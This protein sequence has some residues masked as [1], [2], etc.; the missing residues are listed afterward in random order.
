LKVDS[1][2]LNRAFNPRCVAVVGD[3]KQNDFEW[4]RGQLEFTGKLYSVQVNPDTIA[5]IE[6]L[7]VKN[8]TSLLDI[9]EPVDLAIVAVSRNIAPKVL[10]DC[11]TKD[12][13]AAHF[14]TAGF[15]ETGTEEGR[16]LERQLIERVEDTN[17]HLI[18]PNCMGIFN[19]KL[20]IRQTSDQYTGVSGPVGF[21]AQSGAIAA[22]FSLEAHLQ[23]LDINK[24]VSSGNGI[25]LDA[26]DFLEY[27]GGDPE[28]K[29]IG[30]Y[31]EGVKN[32]RKFFEVLRRVAKLKPVVIWKGGRSEDG[33]RAIASHTGALAMSRTVWDTMVKQCGAVA[34]TGT[35]SLIDTLKALIYLPPVQSD[36]VAVAG[37]SGG[38]SVAITDALAD[39]GFRVPPLTQESYDELATFFNVV[40][41]SYRNP[42]DTAG[43]VRRDMRRILG[44]VEQDANIDN[45]VMVCSTKPGRR[46]MPEQLQGSLDLAQYIKD[47]TTKPVMVIVFLFTPDADREKREI[48]FRY[49]E[50]GI[51]AF[52]SIERGVLALRNTLDYHRFHA[53][54]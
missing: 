15:S 45:L 16:E 10:E 17:F 20:G 38:Q 50:I 9:P 34:V 48:I 53:G 23:G 51:P 5:A 41:G 36:R 14:F 22:M 18:G 30:M 27:F 12:V 40:G 25:A 46:I 26:T 2:K 49:Q 6:D 3:S 54:S 37:G 21:I 28:V 42:I 39:V 8:Y 44:I 4:L 33:D 24:S 31:M 19:P 32:G 29:A 52:P 11:I 1:G 43:P 7:G 13:A 35:E 47:R